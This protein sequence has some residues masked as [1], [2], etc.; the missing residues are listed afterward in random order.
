MF[1][2]VSLFSFAVLAL[3]AV[4]LST[5]AQATLPQEPRRDP[6]PKPPRRLPTHLMERARPFH[7]AFSLN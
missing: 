7:M 1:R 4:T 6:D 3:A 5:K 2:V